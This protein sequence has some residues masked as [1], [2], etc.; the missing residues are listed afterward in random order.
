MSSSAGDKTAAGL[1]LGVGSGGGVGVASGVGDAGEL[2]EA[3]G[4]LGDEVAEADDDGDA[5]GDADGSTGAGGDVVGS[6]WLDR[7]EAA[8]GKMTPTSR[9]TISTVSHDATTGPAPAQGAACG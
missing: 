5:D 7:A 6:T 8:T 3:G 4:E 1:G 9:T 2:G